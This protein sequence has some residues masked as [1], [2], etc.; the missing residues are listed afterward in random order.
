[1][2]FSLIV[3][4]MIYLV[5]PALLARGW[6]GPYAVAIPLGAGFLLMFAIIYVGL[7]R[8]GRLRSWRESLRLTRPS[9]QDIAW[10]VGLG[11][12]MIVSV[13]AFEGYVQDFIL[14]NV[15]MRPP[16]WFLDVLKTSGAV[17]GTPGLGRWDFLA[18]HLILFVLNIFGEELLFRGYMLPRQER[19]GHRYAWVLN[20]IQWTAFHWFWFHVL[21]AILPT[22]LL[23]AWITLKRKSTWCAIIGHGMLNGLAVIGT[24]L[25]VA[26]LKG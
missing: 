22:S 4:A 6:D 24:L 11:L 19:L 16:Q 9:G 10:G 14:A 8:E 26:G 2:A 3:G 7:R 23:L 5:I 17:F 1:M 21:P 12:S 18:L 15:S 25:T 13:V 20:G